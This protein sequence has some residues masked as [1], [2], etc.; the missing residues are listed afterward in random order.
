MEKKIRKFFPFSKFTKLV[1]LL[2]LETQGSA[3]GSESTARAE[4]E[5]TVV[6]TSVATVPR[7]TVRCLEGVSQL[8][9]RRLV[10]QPSQGL[11]LL[12]LNLLV[13]LNQG[14]PVLRPYPSP[15]ASESSGVP[16][17]K[18]A[19]VAAVPRAS[20]AA[21]VPVPKR[22]SA[23]IAP[24][25]TSTAVAE[26][27][28]VPEPKRPPKKKA[29]PSSAVPEREV[30]SSERR[31][32]SRSPVGTAKKSA[33]KKPPAKK[34]PVKRP[35]VAREEPEVEESAPASLSSLVIPSEF[36]RGI[37][38]KTALLVAKGGEWR[39]D[40]KGT[41]ILFCGNRTIANSIS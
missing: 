15:A 27:P 14:D 1:N 9:G 19:S 3:A 28:G 23:P 5:T 40:E 33:A 18:R 16:E 17:P 26:S 7:R 8:P 20:P 34:P 38:D 29:R 22:S 21:G 4:R 12:F 25:A 31:E 10:L 30:Q 2:V 35:P 39:R 32:R 37:I 36:H 24:K 41:K 11:R 13:Y 6:S